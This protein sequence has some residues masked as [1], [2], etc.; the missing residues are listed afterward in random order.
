[1][2]AAYDLHI[3][4]CLSPCADEEM[5]P[6]TIAGIGKLLGLNVMAL[7]DHNTT[8]NCP[9]FFKACE[10]YGILPIA[11]MELTTAEEIHMLCLFQSLASAQNFETYL[12]TKRLPM[13]NKPE[14]FGRQCIMDE[15]DTVVDEYPLLLSL[16]MP[17]YDQA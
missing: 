11:G 16:P 5:T 15:N 17:K 9:A 8:K 6:A 13:K 7:T 12:D 14:I 10:H 1:M 3:H 2:K 4:S